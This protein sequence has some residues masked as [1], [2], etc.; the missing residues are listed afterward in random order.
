MTSSSDSTADFAGLDTPSTARVR[1]RSR[2]DAAL[3]LGLTAGALAGTIDAVVELREGFDGNRWAFLGYAGAIAAVVGGLF[4]ALTGAWLTLGAALLRRFPALDR[5][6]SRTLLEAFP[7][8]LFFLW[9]PSEWVGEQ[10][11]ELGAKKRA[12]V[13]LAH[14]A[15]PVG[16]L[17]VTLIVARARRWARGGGLARVILIALAVLGAALCYLADRFVLPGLYEQFHY[18]L[19]GGF[20]LLLALTL[21]FV[22]EGRTG[23]PLG[24]KRWSIARDAKVVALAPIV[25]CS[26]F[27]LTRADVHG[28][29]SALVVSKIASSARARVDF[30]GDGSSSYFGGP[31]CD[32]FDA[33][34][35]PGKFDYPGNG[36]DEDCDGVEPAWPPP[37]PEPDYPVPQRAGYN[38]V[39][40][41]I[42][43]L[44]ADH[45]GT[46][47]YSRP[48]TPTL[49]ALAERSLLFEQAYAQ[50]SKTVMSLPSLLTGLYPGNLPR[51]YDHP[52]VTRLFARA[53]DIGSDIPSL[54]TLLQ[55]KGYDTCSFVQF[56]IGAAMFR[57]FERV[58]IAKGKRRHAGI[59][60]LREARE[61]FFFWTHLAGPHAPYEK[62]PEF[63][64]G[65]K[66][67][68][69]Y[70]NEIA[71]ADRDVS[72]LLAVLEK[73]GIDDRTIVVV[74]AD[75]GEEFGEHGGKFHRQ[76]LYHELLHVPLIVHVPGVSPRRFA[77]PVE[78]VDI[79]PTLAETLELSATP[80][81]F[82]GQSLWAKLAGKGAASQEGAYADLFETRGPV[83][84]RSLY[85]GRWRANWDLHD[86]HIEL[87]DKQADWAERHDVAHAHPEVADELKA[88]LTSRTWR[89]AAVA[90]QA[91]ERSRD[92]MAL[93]S[94]ADTIQQLPMV[95]RML[96]QL[97]E[98]ERLPREAR[99]PLE[100][101]LE[102][103]LLEEPQRA[104]LRELIARVGTP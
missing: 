78:L 21:A 34:V 33:S 14:V 96:T 22:R 20:G 31:D 90:F 58:T 85:R 80:H 28:P 71:V 17:C 10:W 38:V 37:L 60:G 7:L 8:A 76:V 39:L 46:Y 32:D 3:S 63:D 57:G 99:A 70:D 30:D 1:E 91:Y 19:A 74:T 75:H 11:S 29:S 40:I 51:D 53:F 65:D 64:F 92:P 55:D 24:G 81:D 6:H 68:D 44:R 54:P 101:L 5:R 42:D 56:T 98:H 87:Y 35:G 48:T 79:A 66:D 61:P 41:T 9:I 88:A 82:D 93:L 62:H 16:A 95:D 103:S 43:A 72:K 67:I 23:E 77:A 97:L 83:F 27:E 73:R 89:R 36:V 26:F 13:L 69:R 50:A 86:R 2:F 52:K 25:V 94:R 15:L 47:G 104:R 102:R 100:R 12:L 49:D 4:G 59:R 18:G 84:K 45:V